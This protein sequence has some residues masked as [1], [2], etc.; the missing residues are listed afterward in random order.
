MLM[1][2]A[3]WDGCLEWWRVDGA[4][5]VTRERGGRMAGMER[6]AAVAHGTGGGSSCRLEREKRGVGSEGG[7]GEFA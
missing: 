1:A 6:R 4:R 2:M 3:M 5:E 7:G